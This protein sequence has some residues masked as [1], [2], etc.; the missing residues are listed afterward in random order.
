MIF[1]TLRSLNGTLTDD[2]GISGA[3]LPYFHM[4][5]CFQMLHLPFYKATVGTLEQ[6]G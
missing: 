5:H 4:L 3:L 2:P 1:T 6:P